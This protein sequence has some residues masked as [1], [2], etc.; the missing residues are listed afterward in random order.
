LRRV[1]AQ[2]NEP[3]PKFSLVVATIGRTTQLV[4][5]F[6]TLSAQTFQSF[7]VIVADQNP[8][9]YLAGVLARFQA[10]FPIRHLQSEPGLSRARNA[11]LDHI[12]G[13]FVAFPDD[14]CW[15]PEDLLECVAN[16]LTAHPDWDGL[17]GMPSDP[18][19]PDGFRGFHRTSGELSLAN[20]WRR[21]TSVTI[22]LR[23]NVVEIVGRF[24]EDLGRG[25]WTGMTSAEE[26]EY[27]IRALLLGC[28]IFYSPDMRVFHRAWRSN[29]ETLVGRAFGDL[30]ALGYVL[31]KYGFPLRLLLHRLTRMLGGMAWFSMHGN[32]RRARFYR[33]AFQGLLVGWLS[34]QHPR[35]DAVQ[36]SLAGYSRWKRFRF[37][38][39]MDSG[40]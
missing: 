21:S 31:R 22:F 18:S 15:Y 7:E 27:L 24:D 28:H 26:S 34:F 9:G 29:E 1:H 3:R 10:F 2:M 11:A 16:G 32:Q 19:D 4:R 38:P 14:D 17:T 40:A 6:E 12:R 25:A 39:R 13:E 5:L 8:P 20:L 36:E 37:R 23:R 30:K 33:L 35:T